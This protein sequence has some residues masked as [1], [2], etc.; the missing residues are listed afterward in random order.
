MRARAITIVIGV[1][2]AGVM[3]LGAQTATALPK[4]ETKLSMGWDGAGSTATWTRSSRSARS[5][6]GWSCSSSDP[7]PITGSSLP[8]P[9]RTTACEGT[10]DCGVGCG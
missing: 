9:R 4:Y 10:T 3:A 6:G 1:A 8:E 5:G 2:A 7:G